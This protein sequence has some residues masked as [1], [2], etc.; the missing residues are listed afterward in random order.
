[1]H[2]DINTLL[3]Y[4]IVFGVLIMSVIYTLIRYIYS[5][6]LIYLSYCAMQ[7]FSLMYFSVH[8]N[9]FDASQGAQDIFLFLALLGATTFAVAFQ[10]GKLG[11]K[12]GSYRELL[13]KTALLIAVLA[14]AFYHYMLFEYPPYTII[15]TILSIS[16]IFNLK[17]GFKPMVIYAVG[18]SI[19]CIILFVFE[20]KPYFIQKGYPD[21]SLMAFG[22]EATLFTIAVS[23]KDNIIKNRALDYQNML[24]QQSKMAQSGEMIA[25]ITHQ[26]RQPLNNLSYILMNVKKQY[27]NDKL[28]PEY[29][30][31]KFDA[32]QMQLLFMSKTIDEFREFYMP[33][34][35][36]EALDVR[37]AIDNSIT[38]LRA[39]LKNREI[40]L[41]QDFE[42][43]NMMVFGKKNE[44]SQVILAILSNAVDALQSS[45]NPSIKIGVKN[46]K[47]EVVITI[48]DNGG[49]VKQANIQQIFEPYFSTKQSGTGIGLY[50]AKTIIEHS[51]DGD[52]EVKNIADGAEFAIRLKSI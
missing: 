49:G 12:I 40:E 47:S 29:F 46:I 27:A 37:H 4:G 32:A 15:Y 23:Y 25:N 17:P 14:A 26:F 11:L 48:A 50:I 13:I 44:L 20:L 31:K 7:A 8:S 30:E 39:E 43:G 42:A 2:F 18:W 10:E 51:F 21:I 22:A 24:L 45:K 16:V 36:K 6:E 35:I 1:M 33:S 3:A 9:L 41:T 5:K 52:I 28:T 34:K 19:L 38:I